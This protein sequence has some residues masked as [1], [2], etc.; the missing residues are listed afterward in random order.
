MIYSSRYTIVIS[1]YLSLDYIFNLPFGIYSDHRKF[2]LELS[3]EKFRNFFELSNEMVTY[4]IKWE[5]SELQF[6]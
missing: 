1:N 4:K 2:H 6:Y 3:N 5:I